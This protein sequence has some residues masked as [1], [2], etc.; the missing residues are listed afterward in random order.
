MRRS[1]EEPSG[2]NEPEGRRVYSAVYNKYRASLVY[3]VSIGEGKRFLSSSFH[4][5]LRP[6]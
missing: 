4:S 3:L 5:S 6:A 2:R 1:D